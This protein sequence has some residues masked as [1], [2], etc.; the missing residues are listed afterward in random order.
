MQPILRKIRVV[1]TAVVFR[2][3]LVNETSTYEEKFTFPY[4]SGSFFLLEGPFVV[5]AVKKLENRP[6]LVCFDAC[7]SALKRTSSH[8]WNGTRNSEHRDCQERSNWKETTLQDRVGKLSYDD[9]DLGFVTA[10]SDKR[11]WSP[12]YPVSLKAL[13]E[14]ISQYEKTCLEAMKEARKLA[15][16]RL[17]IGESNHI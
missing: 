8:L 6:D 13:E 1:A 4:I 2:D 9:Q 7:T 12:G 3:C 15:N 10:F 11:F 5:A 16:A 14:I 17:E